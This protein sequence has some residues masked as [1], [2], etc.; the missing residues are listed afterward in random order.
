MNDS[1]RRALRTIFDLVPAV[2]ATLA[3]LVPLLDLDA[4][5]VAKIGALVA[6]ITVVFAKVRNGLEDAGVIPA[7]LKAPASDGADPVPDTRDS[8]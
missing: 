4:G 5:T 6:T 7:V 8:I 2:L 3:V 1:T